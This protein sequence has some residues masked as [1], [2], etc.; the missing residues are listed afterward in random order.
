MVTDLPLLQMKPRIFIGSS[1]EGL[2]VAGLL[3][4]HLASFTECEIWNEGVFGLNE[5]YL[6]TLIK[7]PNIYDF[8]I[9]I[10][11]KD[12]KV[13]ARK[14]LFDKA[15]DNVIFELG[16]FMGKLHK[17]RVF[18]L[19][20]DGVTLPS[21]MMGITILPF[22]QN[23]HKKIASASLKKVFTTLV[24]KIHDK[25]DHFI[26]TALP[27]TALAQGYYNNFVF[28]VS[29]SLAHNKSVWLKSGNK[30]SD[31]WKQEK[32]VKEWKKF[33]LVIVVPDDL[34]KDYQERIRAFTRKNTLEKLEVGSDTRD[35]NFYLNAA[36]QPQQTLKLYDIPTTLSSLDNAI[37]RLV[38]KDYE[39][40][41]EKLEALLKKRAIANFVKTLDFLI[42]EKEVTKNKVHIQVVDI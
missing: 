24:A 6:E 10:A 7:I 13:R 39:G 35:Y 5:S 25:D 41:E 11:T 38:P 30:E 40:K 2:P 37:D 21:D 4:K 1:S 32:K 27:S 8:A 15:R 34:H 31:E 18:L 16:L 17:K 42:S 19:Q 14:K 33:E 9:L 20:E 3:K 28:P 12:E 23:A 22:K 26:Y 29:Q 36:Q